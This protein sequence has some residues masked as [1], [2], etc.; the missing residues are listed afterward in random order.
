MKFYKILILFLISLAILIVTIL[1]I[2]E[3]YE[4]DDDM[5]VDLRKEFQA[6]FPVEMKQ[7]ILLRGEKSYTINKKRVYLCLRDAD[8]N[9][10]PKNMLAYVLLHELAHVKCDEIGHTEKFHT[11][12]N[13]L[14]QTAIANNL[15]DPNIPIIRD[16]CEYNS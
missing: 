6:V 7:V 16:Y 15:Y 11:I 9:Y 2:K 4:E 1:R 3:K 14:L 13:Q 12:F 5:L 8:N 10:Y